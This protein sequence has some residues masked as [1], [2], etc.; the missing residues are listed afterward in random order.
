MSAGDSRALPRFARL[1]ID[2][3]RGR[4]IGRAS[5]SWYALADCRPSDAT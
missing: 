1:G 3:L 4:D 5:R 2:P